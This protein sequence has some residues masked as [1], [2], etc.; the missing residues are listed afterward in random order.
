MPNMRARDTAKDAAPDIP[1]TMFVEIES[2]PTEIP[3]WFEYLAR[4]NIKLITYLS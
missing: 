1:S 2:P 4:T 3:D